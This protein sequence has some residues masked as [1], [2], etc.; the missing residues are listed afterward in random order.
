MPR[1]VQRKHLGPVQGRAS[2][3]PVKK[4]PFETPET[5]EHSSPEGPF[6]S[7]GD[8]TTSSDALQAGKSVPGEPTAGGGIGLAGSGP[9]KPTQFRRSARAR[10][11]PNRF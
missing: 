11:P 1:G 8:R 10:K 5:L 3:T 7:A 2:S 4:E 6:S 9:T